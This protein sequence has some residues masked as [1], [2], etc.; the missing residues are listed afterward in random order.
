MPDD[1]SKPSNED[2]FRPEA[3]AQRIDRL[4]EET[5]S[6]RVA[7][8]E[9]EK[10]LL[11]KE[12]KKGGLESAA[13]KRLNRI[14]EG[15]VKRPP[16]F[17]AIPEADPL[18]QQAARAQK[19]IHAHQGVFGTLIACAALGLA[20]VAGSFYLQ[21]RR[22]AQASSLLARAIA[23]EHGRIAATNDDADDESPTH[24]IYPRFRSIVE[25][26]DAA[27]AAYRAVESTCSGSGAAIL[28]RL[29]EGSLLLDAGDAKQAIAA[30][31]DVKDS[32]LARAD[33]EVR[34]RALEG[35]GFAEELLAQSEGANRSN[36]LD[37]A[38]T[39]YK[40]LEAVDVNQF[41]EFGMY[42]Q[43][44]VLA[45][46]GNKAK[47]IALLKEASKRINGSDHGSPSYLQFV[48][49]DRLGELDPSSLPPRAP[50][51]G[52]TATGA[53]GP[54]GSVDMNDPKIQE[55]LRQLQ[56]RSPQGGS[57]SPAKEPTR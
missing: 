47:A 35:I 39:D 1:H 16:A 44:R 24:E 37:A 12:R 13:S 49:E 18:L 9:E 19:W 48:V 3:I 17:A 29:S 36:H 55:I 2:R 23:D 52:A 15:Y 33:A 57:T 32:A 42:H 51:A 30:Y 10:L 53:G 8:E 28:A 4:G 38:L 14:G 7:R 6:D 11:R 21:H 5:T 27:L 41:K 46:E 50:K 56:Q 20:A 34:G 26:R 54:A 40:A 45:A 43:A 22:E 31:D 25:R